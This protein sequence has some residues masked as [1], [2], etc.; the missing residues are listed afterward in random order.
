MN[1]YI[2]HTFTENTFTV[3]KCTN[4]CTC[5]HMA[6]LLCCEIMWSET[7]I[8]SKK[9]PFVLIHS[10]LD[11]TLSD[12]QDFLRRHETFMKKSVKH[13]CRCVC[14]CLYFR[15]W[16]N[17][18]LSQHT[19]YFVSVAYLS[20]TSSKLLLCVSIPLS[21]SLYLS[22]THSLTHTHKH[23]HTHTHTPHSSNISFHVVWSGLV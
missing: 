11:C 4:V 17:N 22:L 21:F 14:V 9:C 12:C 8:V 16:N 18:L 15:V 13:N 20:Y 10:N 2:Q 19:T 5:T 7:F 1:A 3:N 6:G 23:T